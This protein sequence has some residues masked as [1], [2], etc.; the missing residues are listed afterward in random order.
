MGQRKPGGILTADKNRDVP[1]RY[2]VRPDELDALCLREKLPRHTE[3]QYN[4]VMSYIEY[5]DPLRAYNDAGYASLESIEAL[6]RRNYKVQRVLDSETVQ[7]LMTGIQEQVIERRGLK[8]D[9]LVEQLLRAHSHAKSATEEI[10]AIKEIGKL[11]GYYDKAERKQRVA[12][13]K[14]KGITELSDFELKRLA[15]P[16]RTL[17][18]GETQV[19]SV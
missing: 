4:F 10:M 1:E 11:L 7:A 5:G 3:K 6:Y 15:K 13:L 18:S 9:H 19:K 2:I 14:E 12:K 16:G 8:V 17:T